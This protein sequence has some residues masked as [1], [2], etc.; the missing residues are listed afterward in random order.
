MCRGNSAAGESPCHRHRD[1]L[2]GFAEQARCRRD[3]Q[4]SYWLDEGAAARGDGGDA[5]AAA[6][7]LVMGWAGEGVPAGPVCY[8]PV[9]FSI[10]RAGGGKG[11]PSRTMD[12]R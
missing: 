8:P 7:G 12:E 2:A 9:E 6:V 4:I 1:C 3:A 10:C 5:I 11:G